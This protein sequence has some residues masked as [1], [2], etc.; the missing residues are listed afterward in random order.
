[1][2]KNQKYLADWKNKKRDEIALYAIVQ[3][4]TKFFNAI[5]DSSE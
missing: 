5:K 1:M 3:L 4:P 2:W